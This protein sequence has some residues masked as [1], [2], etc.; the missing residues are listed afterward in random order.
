MI[1]EIS[2]RPVGQGGLLVGE[3]KV[4]SARLSW[5]Y[6]CGSNQLEPLRREIGRIPADRPLDLLFLSH[7]DNDHVSGV[8]HLLLQVDVEEVVLPYLSELERTLTT[9]EEM[10]RGALSTSFLDFVNSPEGWLFDRGVRRVTFIAPDPGDGDVGPDLPELPGPREPERKVEQFRAKWSRRPVQDSPRSTAGVV[11]AVR[12]FETGASLLLLGNG[13]PLG[14]ILLPYV[15]PP[16]IERLDKFRRELDKLFPDLTPIEIIDMARTRDGRE[17]LRRCYDALWTDHNKVSLSLY[18]GA[19]AREGGWAWLSTGDA[20]LKAGSRRKAFLRFFARLRENVVALV[21]PH[22]G[23]ALSFDPELVSS[24]A[25]PK[26][27][28]GVVASG[29]NKWDHPNEEVVDA[30]K[31]RNLEYRN[32]KE[33]PETAF[34]MSFQIGP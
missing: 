14:A 20:D 32:V 11:E 23:A 15:H 18:M 31:A 26:L 9:A 17:K 24:A 22:H 6:D 19:G 12:V 33:K 8:D 2:Q 21:M 27:L 3:A 7:L 16:S 30:I 13:E 10:A 34:K 28:V 29:K 4:D 5:V 25:F 1:I